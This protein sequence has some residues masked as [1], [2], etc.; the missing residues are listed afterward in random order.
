MKTFLVFDKIGEITEFTT[1]S[2]M[3]N[4]EN[5]A[6]YKHYTTYKEYIILYNVEEPY[7]KKNNRILFNI[8]RPIQNKFKKIKLKPNDII[9]SSEEESDIIDV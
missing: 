3:F 8:Q 4:L 7:Q 1:K 2:S 6:E 5:F 9:Y